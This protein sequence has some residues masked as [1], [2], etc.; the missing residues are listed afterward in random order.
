MNK[1][2]IAI[3]LPQFYPFAENDEWWGKGF[4]EWRNVATATPRFRGHYQPHIPADLG[5]YDLRLEESRLAQIELAKSHGI[6]GFCYYHYWFNGKLIMEVPVE[7]MLNNKKE[8]FP[9][10]LCWANENWHR[11]WEGGFNKV[12]ISQNYNENDDINHFYYLLKFFK[13][14]R[15]IKVNGSPVL[16][17]YR[18]HLFPNI[19]KT[20]DLWQKLASEE[21]FSLYICRFED[22]LHYGEKYMEQNIDAAIEFQPF[23]TKENMKIGNYFP[24]ALRKI[25]NKDYL[26]YIYSYPQLV[27]KQLMRNYNDRGYKL[28]PCAF[29]SWD[30][31]SRRKGRSFTAFKNSTPELFEQWLSHIYDNFTPYS[32]DEDFIFI[33]AWNEWA[34]GCHLEPDLKHGLGYLNAVKKV[35]R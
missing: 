16:C 3:H 9:F 33:N 14:P 12:L 7:R 35:F 30:N 2:A 1:R 17:I 18:T 29:P 27:K 31:S 21:G 32:S 20:I 8:D 5:F 4:T 24:R 13:D 23:I 10:M 6:Y 34:E 26:N 15:Y 25:F 28:Y 22:S 11:N 19:S